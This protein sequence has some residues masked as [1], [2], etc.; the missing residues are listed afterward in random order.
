M[1]QV[2]LTAELSRFAEACVAGGRHRTVDEVMAAFRL[3]QRQEELAGFRHRL[4]AAAAR[5][6]AEGWVE[7]DDA[8]A[9][10]ERERAAPE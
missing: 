6:Q 8:M 5:G 2:T 4:D 1:P 7:L 9:A 3:L 10:V